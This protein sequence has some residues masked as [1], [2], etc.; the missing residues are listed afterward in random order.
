M[1]ALRHSFK[2]SIVW[3]SQRKAYD[4]HKKAKQAF[5]KKKVSINIKTFWDFT[6]VKKFTSKG[7]RKL[8]IGVFWKHKRIRSLAR[9]FEHT[10]PLF[11]LIATL[12][13][14][15]V[16]KF[17]RNKENKILGK[18]LEIFLNYIWNDTIKAQQIF[19]NHNKKRSLAND[20]RSHYKDLTSEKIKR[21]HS[22]SSF[23]RKG[24][25]GIEATVV[26]FWKVWWR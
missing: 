9:I 4:S 20:I 18:S 23:D 2:R 15:K 24:M 19:Y 13:L 7:I 1:K 6:R 17:R 11:W 21:Q 25:G 3:S 12:I 14:I 5:S 10:L 26:F 16:R 8:C 22:L